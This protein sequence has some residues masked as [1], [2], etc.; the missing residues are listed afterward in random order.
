MGISLALGSGNL[1]EI[2]FYTI[3]IGWNRFMNTRKFKRSEFQKRD[4]IISLVLAPILVLVIFLLGLLFQALSFS[5]PTEIKKLRGQGKVETYAIPYDQVF[6]TAVG[7]INERGLTIVESNK[8]GGY[9]IAAE[10]SGFLY[11]GRVIALFFTPEP[12]KNR[13]Q[14][15]V[16]SKLAA[17]PPLKELIFQRNGASQILDNLD[18]H[19]EGSNGNR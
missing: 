12:S 15:E 4:G 11:E 13:T 19:L 5:T 18:K 16:L 1:I 17:L 3:P 14:V 6:Q 9:I 2:N 10:G 8:E 7:S